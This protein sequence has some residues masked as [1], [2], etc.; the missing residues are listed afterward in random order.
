MKTLAIYQVQMGHYV[1]LQL[2]TTIQLQLVL[3]MNE[4]QEMD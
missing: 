3:I 2:L 4:Y 1:L